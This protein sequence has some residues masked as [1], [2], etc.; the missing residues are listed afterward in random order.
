LTT[1]YFTFQTTLTTT[2]ED[3]NKEEVQLVHSV[4]LSRN[5]AIR[6]IEDASTPDDFIALKQA[7]EAAKRNVFTQ[8]YLHFKNAELSD[9]IE[10]IKVASELIED[11]HLDLNRFKSQ[12]QTSEK[13]HFVPEGEKFLCELLA[14]E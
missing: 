11:L 1:T 5:I 9:Q 6:F 7:V 8:R 10:R 2:W 14:Q 13:S 4:Y 12:N 3:R